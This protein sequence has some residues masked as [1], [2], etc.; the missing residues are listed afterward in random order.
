MKAGAIARRP[1]VVIE[2]GSPIREAA[3]IMVE[4]RIG[5]LPVVASGR[6]VGVISERDIVKAAASGVDP[7]SP[8]DSIMR[9]EVVTVQFNDDIEAVWSL[10]KNLGIRHVVVMRG[11]E[12]YGVVSIRDFLAERIALSLMAG[13]HS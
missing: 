11:D 1:V 3:R 6:L 4:R 8:V 9:R 7:S 5:F 10:M 2:S 13:A 12:I